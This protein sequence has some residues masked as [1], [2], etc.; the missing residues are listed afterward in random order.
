MTRL[1]KVSRIFSIFAS[2]VRGIYG[3][4]NM[5]VIGQYLGPKTIDFDRNKKTFW[6]SKINK[7]KTERVEA[8]RAESGCQDLS[9]ETNISLY[10]SP[11]Q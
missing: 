1:S 5:F 9:I 6:Q 11:R 3:L 4:E 7:A 8:Q 2:F 10:D